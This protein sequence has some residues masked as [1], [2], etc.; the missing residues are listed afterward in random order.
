MSE[1]VASIGRVTSI[2]TEIT[3]ASREQTSGIEQIN[4]AIAQMDEVTQRNAALVEQEAAAA[5]A[6]QDQATQLASL[7]SVFKIE[8]AG[9]LGSMVAADKVVQLDER[10]PL[11]K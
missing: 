4:Q 10:R 11:L 1:I 5:D 8:G 6:L 9:G 2:M 3:S 7:V